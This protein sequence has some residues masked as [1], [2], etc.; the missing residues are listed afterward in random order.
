MWNNRAIRIRIK[1]HENVH[2]FIQTLH[3]RHV[4]LK[5]IVFREQEVLLET[6]MHYLPEIRRARRHYRL[7]MAVYYTDELHIF[8]VQFWTLVGLLVM[9]LIPLLCAQI[10]WRVDIEAASPELE[11][12]LMN[13]FQTTFPVQTPFFKRNLPSDALIRQKL[14]EA[15]RELAWVHIEKSGGRIILRPQ[16]SPKQVK[17]AEDAVASYLVA[18]KNGVIT[19]FNIQNGERKLSVNDT[20][21][22]GD[23]LVSGMIDSGT[24]TI[25]VGAKGEVYADYWLECSFKMP[26]KITMAT[27]QQKQW[28][29]AIK[30]IHPEQ[31]D[32]IQKKKLPSWLDSY[33]SIVE[34]QH[35]ETMTFELNESTI[36]SLL[37]PLLHEKIIRSL[38]MKTLIKKENLLQVK[39]EN[40][41]VEGKILYLINENIA[42]P[43]T[44]SHGG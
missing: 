13:T 22:E 35:T 31:V 11:Q 5:H 34:E 8:R 17:Q 9:I 7:K 40:G 36:E 3:A 14:L 4:P 37:L 20:A 27:Q 41:T 30:G 26:T 32:Y 18:T 28:R 1:R 29:I 12:R 24:D 38:P 23:V 33:V 6:T 43:I 42:N 2:P 15:H 44:D 21:Y 39:W 25:F 10:L 19:H 16:E